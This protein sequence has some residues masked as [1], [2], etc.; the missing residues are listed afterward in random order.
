MCV[1]YFRRAAPVHRGAMDHSSGAG[2]DRRATGD[3]AEQPRALRGG[4]PGAAGLADCNRGP[5]PGKREL[6][7]ADRFDVA[8]PYRIDS[9]A[10]TAGT[11]YDTHIRDMIEQVLF[12]S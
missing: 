10:S 6:K 5:G 4:R 9:N 1:Q 11:S 12:T 2:E 7:M 8:Y 3:S